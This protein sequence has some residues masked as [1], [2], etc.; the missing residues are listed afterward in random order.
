MP[1]TGTSVNHSITFAT[2][3][4]SSSGPASNRQHL[5]DWDLKGSHAG[6]L[7]SVQLVTTRFVDGA[8][9][10][11]NCTGLLR[12]QPAPATCSQ[13][14]LGAGPV[15]LTALLP[16]WLACLPIPTVS[17]HLVGAQHCFQK[18]PWNTP[19]LGHFSLGNHGVPILKWR[20]REREE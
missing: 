11:R 15:A 2:A 20:E 6:L 4:Q 5:E 19:S 8:S 1:H 18:L 13:V 10:Y 9:Q 7:A 16:D 17:R 12:V 3:L 14:A